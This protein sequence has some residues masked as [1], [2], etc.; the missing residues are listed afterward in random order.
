[1]R[2]VVDALGRFIELKHVPKRV[3]SIVPSETETIALLAGVEVLVGRT[4]YCVEPRGQIEAVPTVGGT[5]NAKVEAIE[6]LRPDIVFANQEENTPEI[7]RKLEEKGIPVHVSFPKTIEEGRALVYDIAELLGIDPKSSQAIAQM[8]EEL[9]QAEAQR[10]TRR[11]LRVFCP[12]W[13]DPLMTFN[14]E[15][16]MAD[17][18]DLAGGHNIF[19]DR[20]RRYPLAAD[21][22]LAPPDEKKAEGRDTRYPR[23]RIEEVLER[24]PELVLLPDE[25]YPFTEKEAAFF[26]SFGLRVCFVAGRDLSWYGL[27]MGESALRVRAILDR[28]CA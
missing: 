9:A 20:K 8:E 27:R 1:M 6:A 13:F 15:T 28:F 19:G 17:M 24:A 22:G 12:I 5:K 7:V 10:K 4:E 14:D 26:R 2:P 18:L 3:V 25:P 21:L 11:P 16:F 23:V